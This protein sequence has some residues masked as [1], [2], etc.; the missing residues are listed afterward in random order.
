MILSYG[1]I[2]DVNIHFIEN[3]MISSSSCSNFYI[4]SIS[5]LIEYYNCSYNANL[6]IFLILLYM[7]EIVDFVDFPF[8]LV[9]S[10]SL[11]KDYLTSFCIYGINIREL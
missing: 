8:I 1:T 3:L 9:L 7:G 11:Y 2:G 6:D 10:S 5:S 4:S